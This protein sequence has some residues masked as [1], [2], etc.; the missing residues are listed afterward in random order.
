MPKIVDADERR[1]ELAA[2]A[3]EVI[4]TRGIEGAKLRDV[5]QAAGWTTG[6]V[7]HYFADKRELLVFA[8]R[9][10]VERRT[11]SLTEELARVNGSSRPTLQR[12]RILLTG[13]LPRDEDMRNRWRVWLAF[14]GQAM[15][16]EDLAAI[17]RETHQL[18]RETLYGL[19]LHARDRGELSK[20]IDAALE[21]DRLVALVDGIGLQSMFDPD[22]WPATKQ[23]KTV[24]DYVAGL[25][26]TRRRAKGLSKSPV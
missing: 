20:A 13:V 2:A 4:A 7:S 23:E 8:F 15:C 24:I 1:A 17:Q 26:G 9:T 5:A 12:L 14:W 11:L 10:S 3:L 16:D 22:R 6:V 21:A 18:F 25:A 19:L